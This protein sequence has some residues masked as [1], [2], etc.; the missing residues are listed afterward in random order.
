MCPCR[1]VFQGLEGLRD[2]A[3]VASGDMDV[4]GLKNAAEV[5]FVRRAAAQALDRRGLVAEGFKEGI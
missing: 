4:V 2:L 3:A 1:A 5:G